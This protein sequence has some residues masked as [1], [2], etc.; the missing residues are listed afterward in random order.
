MDASSVGKHEP[1]AP[2]A[3]LPR[4]VG[5]LIAAVGALLCWGALIALVQAIA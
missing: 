5:V 2:D 4:S 3:V 1:P